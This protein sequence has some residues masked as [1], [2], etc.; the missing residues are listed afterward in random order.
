MKV[1]KKEEVELAVLR[2]A[3][4]KGLINRKWL[5]CKGKLEENGKFFR[6]EIQAE[7]EM[8]EQKRENKL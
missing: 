7:S 6:R 1:V 3:R 8:G 5:K 4:M 2:G